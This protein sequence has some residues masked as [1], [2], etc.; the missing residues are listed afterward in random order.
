VYDGSQ[1]GFWILAPTPNTARYT[2]ITLAN[3]PAS[4]RI[5]RTF[6]GPV[7]SPTRG[8]E[9]GDLSDG[10]QGPYSSVTRLMNG[11]DVSWRRRELRS[12]AIAYKLLETAEASLWSEIQRTHAVTEEVVFIR[13]MLDRA[14]Q[15]Q[16]GFLGL[17]RDLNALESPMFR[18]Q[19]TGVVLEERGGAPLY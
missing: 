5:G 16:Y 6:V 11:R 8:V 9:Y 4:I 14:L 1:F 15:Q 3:G 12:A 19:A 2:T 10:W 17:M 13:S 7:F 18:F